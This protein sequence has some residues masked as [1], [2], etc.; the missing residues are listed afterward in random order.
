MVYLTCIKLGYLSIGLQEGRPRFD[1]PWRPHCTYCLLQTSSLTARHPIGF[2]GDGVLPVV[3]RPEHEAD[4]S[5]PSGAEIKNARSVTSTSIP[6]GT[7]TT[8]FH[9]GELQVYHY[10]HATVV[11]FVMTNSVP[12]G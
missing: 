3:E 5:P 1:S 2:V 6:V 11:F 4:R 7:G 12:V 9:L 10:Q 8:V